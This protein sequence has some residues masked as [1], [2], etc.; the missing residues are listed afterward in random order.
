MKLEENH[1]G[2]FKDLLTDPDMNDKTV[3]QLIQ[4][5]DMAEMGQCVIDTTRA[6]FEKI[7]YAN[8]CDDLWDAMITLAEIIADLNSRVYEQ[9]SPEEL[10]KGICS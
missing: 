2:K 8:D 3:C 7:N 5:R 9:T 10:T 4:A 6:Q 1:M